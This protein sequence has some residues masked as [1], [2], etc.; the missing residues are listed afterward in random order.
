MSRPVVSFAAISGD[1][2]RRDQHRCRRCGVRIEQVRWAP[3]KSRLTHGFEADVLRR[4]RDCSISG[5]CRQL[6]LHCT[7]V[8]RLIE[9]WGRGVGRSPV[10]QAA[11]CDRR[12]RGQLRPGQARKYLTVWNH[13]PGTRG[14]DRP[15]RQRDTLYAFFATLGT[16][17]SR[18]LRVV[19]WTCAGPTLHS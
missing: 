12:R 13:A 4:A 1:H 7:S 19:T 17:R 15:S 11:A 2:L 3:T 14:L 5:V 9:R 16:R 8:M 6:G 10:S 18:R